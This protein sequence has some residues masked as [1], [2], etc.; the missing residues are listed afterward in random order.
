[1]LLTFITKVGREC[2]FGAGRDLEECGSGVGGTVFAA[3]SAEQDS[4]L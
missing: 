2:S 3:A 1:M 4:L